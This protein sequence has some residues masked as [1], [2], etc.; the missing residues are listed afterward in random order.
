MSLDLA[1]KICYAVLRGDTTGKNGGC[2][3]NNQKITPQ[4]FWGLF[5]PVTFTGGIQILTTNIN[6]NV[7]F[8]RGVKMK[9]NLQMLEMFL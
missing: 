9:L 8:K 2:D 6:I 3:W 7:R 5:K 4:P 1:S